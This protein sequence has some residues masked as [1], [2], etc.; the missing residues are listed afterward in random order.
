MSKTIT[1]AFCLMM[2]LPAAASDKVRI[3]I[4]EFP[5]CVEMSADGTATGFEVDL[6]KT[7]A[8]A[9]GWDYEFHVYDEF[10]NL[11]P[12]LEQNDIDVA[13]A[14]IFITPEREEKVDFS[15]Q[16]KSAGQTLL[17]N[18]H[19]VS[20]GLFSII[21]QPEIV[22]ALIYFVV[23]LLVFAAMIWLV[24]RKHPDANVKCFQ[25]GVSLAF[26][27][28]STIGWGNFFPVTKVGLALSVVMF[29]IGTIFVGDVISTM[30]AIKTKQVLNTDIRGIGDLK[31]KSIATIHGTESV[32]TLER[33]GA[34]PVSSSGENIINSISDA[35]ELLKK[36]TVAAVCFDAPVIEYYLKNGGDKHFVEWQGGQFDLQFYGIAMRE[37]D[38]RRELINRRLLDLRKSV[39]G[40]QSKYDQIHNSWFGEYRGQICRQW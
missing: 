40:R 33:L 9:E 3:G 38:I 36:G 35:I 6:W 1:W 22:R 4:S 12:G 34:I 39:P 29:F 5:P 21:Y 28:K 37:G 26:A 24:E 7:I 30:G 17:L 8:D 2:C 23:I 11:I 27:N 10:A 13:I 18:K 31:G 32:A 25:D 16:Y 20:P 19:F 14:G 15:H